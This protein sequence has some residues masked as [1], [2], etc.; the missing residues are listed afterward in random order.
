MIE[1][2]KVVLVRTG[3]MDEKRIDSEI[4]YQSLS[5]LTVGHYHELLHYFFALKTLLPTDVNWQVLRVKFENDFVL[6]E[7]LGV[8]TVA[9]AR[10]RNGSEQV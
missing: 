3:L 7:Q 9:A 6:V 10:H 1:F 2:R 5:H 8:V 4:S